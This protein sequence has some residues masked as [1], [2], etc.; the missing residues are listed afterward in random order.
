MIIKN[1]NMIEKIILIVSQCQPANLYPM[2]FIL[3]ILKK[4]MS[5]PKLY[6]K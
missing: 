4:T 5:N 2:G 6:D 1:K 3:S